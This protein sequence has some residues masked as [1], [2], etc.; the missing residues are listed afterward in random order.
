MNNLVDVAGSFRDPSGSLFRLDG[1]LY[2]RINQ[3][4]QE[5]YDRLM[6]SGLYAELTAAGMLIPHEAADIGLAQSSDTYQ[7]IRPS[8][9]P[10]IS[11]PYEW[12]FSQLKDAALL[13]LTIQKKA[14]ER[15]MV[16]KDCSAYNIQFVGCKPVFIDTLSFEI[17]R[18]GEPWVAYRQFCQH[19][20][21]PLALM[22]YADIRLNQLFRVHIDGVPL[23]LASRLLPARTRLRFPLLAHIHLHAAAQARFAGAVVRPEHH[24]FSALSFRGLADSLESGVCRLRPRPGRTEWG[25]YYSATNYSDAA[26]DEKARIVKDFAGI[27]WPRMVW[28]LGGNTG[29]YS[30][31]V[32]G[33]GASYAACF[34]IDPAAVER[35]YQA[36]K[37]EK[38]AAILPLLLDLA[39]P[40]AG[41]GW[42]NAERQSLA[43]RGPA[44]L[45]M[46]L[47]L[48]HHL[49]IS[50]NVPL[51][52]IAAFFAAFCT[53]LIV[54]F[55]PK[56]DS[57]VQRLLAS[58][59]DIFADYDQTHFEQAFSRHF[60]IEKRMPIAGSGRILYLMKKN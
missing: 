43:E 49:A 45:V 50:N 15:G 29:V 14:F 18:E 56:N 51:E 21:A 34:D 59:K 31:I 1:V 55:V 47:A 46:A 6:S 5:H 44:D 32:I 41:I 60:R 39:N 26:R 13:T 9:V 42:A 36:G 12:C 7:V 23:D 52:R 57:Q 48:V 33:A 4:Y 53:W 24:R 28:D 27:A 54:E 11:Y 25:D 58:R 19:F 16:L 22:A 35:N 3:C 30:R 10:F 37:A 2:R 40:S 38:N 20:L 17:Y 8:I